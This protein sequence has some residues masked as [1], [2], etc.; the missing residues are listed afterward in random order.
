MA[1]LQQQ[2]KPQATGGEDEGTSASL[3]LTEVYYVVH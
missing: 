2:Q 3:H 1:L